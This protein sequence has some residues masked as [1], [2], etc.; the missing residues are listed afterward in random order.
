[1]TRVGRE[2]PFELFDALLLLLF[3][4]CACAFCTHPCVRRCRQ[5]LHEGASRRL[6]RR[7]SY[8]MYTPLAEDPALKSLLVEDGDDEE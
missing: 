6:R 1:M 3:G 8:S 7:Q 4:W 5:S 2:V